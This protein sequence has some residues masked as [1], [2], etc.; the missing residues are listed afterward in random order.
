MYIKNYYF[1]IL[2]IRKSFYKRGREYLLKKRGEIY[3]ESNI[4]TFQDKINYLLIHESPENKSNIVDK[5]LL[6][7][8]SQKILGKDI[9]PKIL[10]IYKDIDE[11]NLDEL[12]EKFVLK[13][14]H[15]S[16]MNIFCSNKTTFNLNFAKDTLKKWMKINYGL[17]NFE[18]QY[19]NIKKKVFAEEFLVDEMVN[20]KIY[21]FNGIPKLIRVKG[22]INKT[23]LYNIFFINWTIAD[24]E[25][26]NIKYVKD[27]KSILKKPKQFEIM[28]NYSRLLS[29]DFCFCRVDF[30]EEN[31]NIYLSELTFSPFNAEIKYKKKE[32]EIYL[33]SLI[34]ISKICKTN[35]LNSN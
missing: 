6:R 29:S 28:L 11:I 5:I 18:Y 1:Y 8:Y 7:N 9:C 14:N 26:D 22:N 34:N 20:Y 30:Y 19:L 16:G 10:K 17:M 35:R 3:N 13:C 27:E 24:I 23:N 15:G 12:P 32:M 33:G 31:N 2:K 21:C 25:F 4:I